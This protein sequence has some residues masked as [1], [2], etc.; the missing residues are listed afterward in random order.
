MAALEKLFF[1]FTIKI[2]EVRT[3][4]YWEILKHLKMLS[5]ERRMERYRILYI[6]KILE[7][8]TPN[9]GVELAD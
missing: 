6:W 3:K 4:N 1:D 2:P 8:R 5:Q 7:G 9:C